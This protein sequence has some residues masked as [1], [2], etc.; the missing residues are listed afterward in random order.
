MARTARHPFADRWNHNTHHFPL[1][2]SRLP[3]TARRVLDIGCGDGTFCRF[4]ADRSASVV[5]VDVDVSVLPRESGQVVFAATSADALGLADGTFDAVTMSMVLHHGDPARLLGEA[6]RVLAPGGVLLVLGLGR[7]G[8]W[9]DAPREVRDVVTHRL[10][11]RRM[12]P[13]DP[14]TVKADPEL[15]WAETRSVL[16]DELPGCRYERLPLWRYLV[17]WQKPTTGL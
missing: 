7:Y 10:F 16:R 5:G 1:L 17:S 15:T 4:V 9:R 6:V 14:P 11:S 2:R 13:W 3:A 12:T 8:G